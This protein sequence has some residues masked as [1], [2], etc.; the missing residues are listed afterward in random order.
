MAVAAEPLHIADLTIALPDS[1]SGPCASARE[2]RP[3]ESMGSPLKAAAGSPIA[4]RHPAFMTAT[5][6]PALQA[7]MRTD[8]GA[9]DPARSMTPV[10]AS[11]PTATA[12]GSAARRP[13]P[14]P[15][16]G[17]SAPAATV[18]PSAWFQTPEPLS[19]LASVDAT[20]MRIR[21]MPS[22]GS[23]SVRRPGAPPTTTTTATA[24]AIGWRSASSSFLASLTASKRPREA[25][26]LPTAAHG[27]RGTRP[28]DTAAPDPFELLPG[29]VVD[30]DETEIF[31]GPQVS[32]KEAHARGAPELLV[33]RQTLLVRPG[34]PDTAVARHEAARLIQ[35]SWRCSQQRLQARKHARAVGEALRHAAGR[36]SL[37]IPSLRAHWAR[38]LIDA[39]WT[40]ESIE[41][42]II[43]IQAYGRRQAAQRHFAAQRHAARIIQRSWRAYLHIKAVQQQQ[44]A[45]ERRRQRDAVKRIEA[46]WRG[47]GARR[48]AMHRRRA[49]VT[50]QAYAR[51]LPDAALV[52][53]MTPAPPAPPVTPVRSSGRRSRSSSS[54]A[55]APWTPATPPAV[56]AAASVGPRSRTGTNMAI[57]PPNYAPQDMASLPPAA[58]AK[59]TKQITAQNEGHATCT[60]DIATQIVPLRP[61]SP[62]MRTVDEKIMGGIP[63]LTLDL[64]ADRVAA[65][66]ARLAAP[67]ASPVASPRSPQAPPSG[68]RPRDTA[69]AASGRMPGP[70]Q[71]TATKRRRV[72]FDPDRW[73]VFDYEP[74]PSVQG[75]WYPA[76]RERPARPARPVLKRPVCMRPPSPLQLPTQTVVIQRVLYANEM[77]VQDDSDT[78]P[79]TR[80]PASTPSRANNKTQSGGKAALTT[81]SK[82]GPPHAA[83]TSTTTTPSIPRSSKAADPSK[84]TYTREQFLR[85]ASSALSAPAPVASEPALARPAPSATAA[86]TP[87]ARGATPSRLDRPARR[88]APRTP[89]TPSTASTATA[90]TPARATSR[91]RVSASTAPTAPTA[92]TV[93]AASSA[94]APAPSKLAATPALRVAAMRSKTPAK[95]ASSGAAAPVRAL[96]VLDPPQRVA[97]PRPA[98]GRELEIMDSFDLPWHER[99]AGRPQLD[100]SYFETKLKQLK[101]VFPEY[102]VL[103]WYNTGAGLSERDLVVQRQFQEMNESA[104]LLQLNTARLRPAAAAVASARQADEELPVAL[105]EAVLDGTG[106]LAFAQL[107]C[108]I[109][110]SEPERIAVEHVAHLQPDADDVL[111]EQL[112]AQQST[113]TKLEER[114]LRLVGFLERV[115][116]GGDAAPDPAL[117]R[118]V[119][120]IADC[121]PAVDNEAALR[122]AAPRGGLPAA[123]TTGASAPD[124]DPT[125]RETMLRRALEDEA[126]DAYAA[127]FLDVLTQS[128][129]TLNSVTDRYNQ[130]APHAPPMRDL[131]FA[132]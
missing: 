126:E 75:P 112:L 1:P 38:A 124:A 49:I 42:H 92:S 16:R 15:F 11:L 119:V 40:I 128:V 106:A 121:L 118:H 108:Q 97:A 90:P 115:Q 88:V 54:P 43:R 105:W 33:R 18:P 47:Y 50:I 36:L 101:I 130:T 52:T 20:P 41:A 120:A 84:P 127:T 98:K 46:A 9:T 61:P 87:A 79:L 82:P 89:A 114:V 45:N 103:G 39:T 70:D 2:R 28:H 96:R 81:P 62:G 80:D 107:A 32:A 59:L 102:D 53:P 3:I 29:Y 5:P 129:A 35:D 22:P 14:P 57:F 56:P 31:F 19:A 131:F 64:L 60:F 125:N 37:P 6:A 93:L 63:L 58:V 117:V 8:S 48:Q 99:I 86:A 113:V 122:Q 23:P 116:R 72:M 83:S 21:P 94:A 17:T 55:P 12:A 85:T 44:A 76:A 51:R 30:D 110:S 73:A 10:T 25:L 132:K 24:A 68:K 26:D 66:K 109:Q 123:A 4:G 78:D 71:A 111:V 7:A 100:R 95:P 77:D 69:E 65:E 34:P 27:P 104:I 67:S 13:P 91:R 74:G